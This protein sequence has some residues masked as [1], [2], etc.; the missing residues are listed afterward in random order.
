M[1]QDV[2]IGSPW[3][4]ALRDWQWLATF[5]VVVGCSPRTYGLFDNNWSKLD[6]WRAYM[7][8]RGGNLEGEYTWVLT[9]IYSRD[10]MAIHNLWLA[11]S[12]TK[13]QQS[14]VTL[15]GRGRDSG[16]CLNGEPVFMWHQNHW[17]RRTLGMS[18]KLIQVQGWK[19]MGGILISN[20]DGRLSQWVVFWVPRPWSATLCKGII[21]LVQIEETSIVFQAMCGLRWLCG[22]QSINEHCE[23]V[24]NGMY[25]TTSADCMV[26]P[27]GVLAYGL[28]WLL[29]SRSEFSGCCTNVLILGVA[30]QEILHGLRPTCKTIFFRKQ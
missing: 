4:I 19:R 5:F 26:R 30:H 9:K 21:D 28:C 2:R 3:K 8:E 25:I 13:V 11:A 6:C 22:Q 7:H 18:S 15:I 23:D 17:T 27:R 14:R 12:N 20:Q 29:F 24:I 16:W 1:L 10:G